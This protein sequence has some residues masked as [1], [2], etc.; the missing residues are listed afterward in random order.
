MAMMKKIALLMLA[1]GFWFC[2]YPVTCCEANQKIGVLIIGSGMNET[3]RPDWIVG[4][5]DQFFP[6]FIP[7]MLTGGQLEGG[8][9]F[10]L[11][12]YANE[13]EAAV[14]SQVSGRPIA[15]G[16]PIDIFCKEY[17]NLENY[18]VHAISEHRL[19]GKNG[20]FADLLSWHN[21]LFYCLRPQ[22]H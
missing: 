16:T 1:A 9:C 18:P 4:Y 22:H 2:T 6:I 20:F 10:S 15:Q 8:T 19:F 13:A 21:P 11:I 14:C 17:T 3:Y 12:H 5:T 7:G